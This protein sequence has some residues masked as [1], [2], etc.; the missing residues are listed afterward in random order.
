MRTHDLLILLPAPNGSPQALP[1]S[2][3]ESGAEEGK[4]EDDGESNPDESSDE[5]EEE[6]ALWF[7]HQRWFLRLVQGLRRRCR[8]L[9]TL[10]A[11][12]SAARSRGAHGRGGGRDG[13]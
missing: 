2:D 3:S 13:E 5:S 9:A 1:W 7:W 4:Q 12:R 6:P 8:R 10:G 11:S